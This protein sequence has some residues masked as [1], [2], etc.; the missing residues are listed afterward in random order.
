MSLSPRWPDNRAL[1]RAA[2][3]AM[4][5]SLVICAV[6]G[7]V[8]IRTG[9]SGLLDAMTKSVY[10][11]YWLSIANIVGIELTAVSMILL[12]VRNRDGDIRGA[13]YMT[14]VLVVSLI[15][16]ALLSVVVNGITWFL[17]AYVVQLV[18]VVTYQVAND[19][20]LGESVEWH[21][22]GWW[23]R[24][25][26]AFAAPFVHL[27][28]VE[29]P[30]AEYRSIG[31]AEVED[32]YRNRYIPL[33]VF[34]ILSIFLVGSFFGCML[35][36][37]WHVLTEGFFQE[38]A[39]LVFGPFTPIYGCGAVAMTVAL[40]RFWRASWW[41]V[42]MVSGVVG[43]TVEYITSWYLEAAVGVVAWDYTGT[44]GNVGGRINVFF[45]FVWG[46]LGL[47]WVKMFLPVI[48]R[49]V[50]AIPVA[51]RAVVTSVVFA[52]LLEDI[53]LTTVAMDG[54]SKRHD[55]INPK[56]NAEIWVAERFDD[57]W[58]ARRFE[59]MEFGDQ[60]VHVRIEEEASKF[61][62]F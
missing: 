50:D 59:K 38:R 27:R 4:L 48:M 10:D 28:L 20:N 61:R 51:Y 53:V 47:L 23:R 37:A 2:I 29:L 34:N 11:W 17:V 12:A 43:C 44:L 14:R 36:D 62:L 6:S 16:T 13:R 42:M 57:E 24:I 1:S 30:E 45:F 35:E 26:S 9:G 52:F 8:F 18:C 19:P 58:M 21:E 54:Y 32:A 3:V 33:N 39:G 15:A 25:R 49:L 55:G 40:N 5:S 56:S 41:K 46:M 22:L 7:V 31:D 60:A